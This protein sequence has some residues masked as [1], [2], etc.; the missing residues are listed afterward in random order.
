M[1]VIADEV[2]RAGGHVTGVIPQALWD[3]EVGHRGLSDNRI[4]STMHERKALMA[5]LSD[6]FIAMPGGVGTMEEFFEVW[7]WALLGVHAKPCG[8]LNARGYFDPLLSFIDQMVAKRF[9]ARD[10]RDMVIVEPEPAKLMRRIAEYNP[11]A[12]AKWLDTKST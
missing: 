5:E 1:G 8:I 9:L 12:V 4:V 11:P 3:R 6:G 10:F 7:T 2:L